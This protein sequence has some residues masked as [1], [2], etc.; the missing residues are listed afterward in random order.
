MMEELQKSL[1]AAVS[2]AVTEYNIAI[3]GLTKR[4]VCEVFKQAIASGDFTRNVCVDKAGQ[5][6]SY[7]PF[8]EKERL[9]TLVGLLR[10]VLNAADRVYR[11]ALICDGRNVTLR[12]S[13]VVMLLKG[14]IEAVA[15]HDSGKE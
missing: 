6:V 7:V 1:D 9:E 15:N 5:S 14:P 13:N 11:D 3:E 8:R 12:S 4:Q 2:R 10:D